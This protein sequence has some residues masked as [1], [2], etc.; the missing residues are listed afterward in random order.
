M[1]LDAPG[2][3]HPRS[4]QSPEGEHHTNPK[5]R[6]T[7]IKQVFG[8]QVTLTPLK[9]KPAESIS[10]KPGLFAQLKYKMGLRSAPRRALVGVGNVPSEATERS[11]SGNAYFQG[12]IDASTPIAVLCAGFDRFSRS[13]STQPYRLIALDP[14]LQGLLVWVQT[15]G[16]QQVFVVGDTHFNSSISS[17]KLKHEQYIF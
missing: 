2:F 14:R 11:E 9:G 3:V 7:P 8:D 6:A 10:E 16:F 5:E 4:T 13:P 15:P 17:M 12:V 1:G